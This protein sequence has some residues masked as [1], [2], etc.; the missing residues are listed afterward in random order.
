[1][2]LFTDPNDPSNTYGQAV[3][4]RVGDYAHRLGSLLL[5]KGGASDAT[6]ATQEAY[7][8]HALEAAQNGQAPLPYADFVRQMNG[9]NPRGMPG[10]Q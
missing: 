5:G 3:K 9:A 4:D 2:G 6:A 7:R 1:M 10:Q 8:Q